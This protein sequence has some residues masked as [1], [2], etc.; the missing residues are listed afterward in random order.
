MCQSVHIVSEFLLLL[1][2][3]TLGAGGALGLDVVTGVEGCLAA[4]EI[5]IYDELDV[6]NHTAVLICHCLLQ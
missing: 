5:C 4:V 6:G 1:I 3:F 2:P